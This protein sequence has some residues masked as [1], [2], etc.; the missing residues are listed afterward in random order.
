MN[1]P[2]QDRIILNL[3]STPPH[4]YTIPMTM[5]WWKRQIY[6]VKLEHPNNL[7]LN[8]FA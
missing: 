3:S 2:K 8:E 6:F 5:N 4:C 1:N 7:I